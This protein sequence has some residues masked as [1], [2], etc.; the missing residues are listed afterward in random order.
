M[1]L[2]LAEELYRAEQAFIITVHPGV[3]PRLKR[4]Y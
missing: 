3:K 2:W 4:Q 1:M